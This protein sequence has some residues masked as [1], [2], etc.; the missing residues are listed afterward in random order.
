[1]IIAVS[2][3][4]NNRSAIEKI[5]M[6]YKDEKIDGFLHLGDVT[7][8]TILEPLSDLKTDLYLVKGN[9]DS[10]DLETAKILKDLGFAYSI[11]PFEIFIENYGHITMMHE[12]YFIDE[13]T[14]DEKTKY[15]FYGHTHKKEHKI[16]SGKHIINPGSLS[17]Y[18]NSRL[19]Y[20]VI[21]KD[22]V[23]FKAV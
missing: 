6:K 4:H 19:S 23:T 13:Y 16:K 14:S 2:D 21:E 7:D 10:F 22:S 18:Y 8:F 9:G 15:I 3:T 11:P 17:L 5:V 20:V 12:P 1:M